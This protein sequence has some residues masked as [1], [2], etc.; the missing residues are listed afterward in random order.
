MNPLIKSRILIADHDQTFLDQLADRLLQ[1][2]ME[3]DF[4]ENGKT[5]I[6]L[7]ESET[8][9]LIITEIAMPLYN[10]LEILRKAKSTNPNTPILIM[11]YEVTQDWAEQAVREGAYE[12]LLRPLGDLSIFD[13]AVRKGLDLTQTTQ[14]DP[15]FQNSFSKEIFDT[16][17]Q[18]QATSPI[19]EGRITAE[20]QQGF[21]FETTH[22]PFEEPAVP[23]SQT[24]PSIESAP[25]EQP[26]DQIASLPE[27]VIELN[28]KG[29]ILSCSPAARNWL[30]LEANS[31]KKPILELLKNL[32]K[33]ATPDNMQ[34]QV[35]GRQ[36]HLAIKTIQDRMGS[37]RFILMIREAKA[38]VSNAH[39]SPA[40]GTP[41][42]RSAAQPPVEQKNAF[43]GSMKKYQADSQDHG[44]S[45]LGF[46]DQMKNAIK[47]EV[48][49]IKEQT[50]FELFG[51]KSEEV[52]P[53]MVF[54]MSRRISDVS[55]GRRTSF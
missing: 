3:V 30:M 49:K 24:K 21:K 55:R 10:G 9:D 32:G 19:G 6:D 11:S 7:I 5:A 47:G 27:G 39:R 18:T 50:P 44:W 31:S 51:S 20:P 33:Q 40:M 35:S 8:Y 42:S 28:G 17:P 48:E 26:Q 54:T 36:A 4:A 1:M 38:T 29:Q 34:V 52:D 13:I 15:T 37:E 25:W 14:Q 16:L 53:E 2:E 43:S 45:P 23:S 12:Y 41:S 46:F 22:P